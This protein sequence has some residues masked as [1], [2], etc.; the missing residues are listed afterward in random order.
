[1]QQKD[2]P[3]LAIVRS[4]LADVTNAAKTSSPVQTDMQLLSLLRKRATA[5]QTAKAEFAGAGRQ[6]LVEQEEQQ[7]KVLEDVRDAVQ[8]VVEEGKA[9]LAAGGKAAN[10]GD[11]LKKLLGAGGSLEGKNVERSEVA[12]V[13]TE[14][15]AFST[16]IIIKND[17]A[18]VCH[19]LRIPPEIRTMIWEYTV[20]DTQCQYEAALFYMRREEQVPEQPPQAR[21]LDPVAPPSLYVKLCCGA[22]LLGGIRRLVFKIYSLPEYHRSQHVLAG[23]TVSFSIT[24]DGQAVVGINDRLLAHPE[25]EYAGFMVLAK[26]RMEVVRARNYTLRRAEVVKECDVVVG[27]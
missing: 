27:E 18:P 26:L 7:A 13:R 14:H 6:D 12:R 11:V 8:R 2:K 23:K 1:M 24:D 22:D 16:V 17:M 4:L 9:V 3:R 21:A 5:A 20:V 25:W 10:M 19:L 15:S